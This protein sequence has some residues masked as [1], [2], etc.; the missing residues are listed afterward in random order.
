MATAT[1]TY[2]MSPLR[3][4]LGE[5]VAI[6]VKETKYEFLKLIRTK[7]FSLSVIGFPV[8]FYIFFGLANR[9]SMGK[10]V[11]AAKYMLAGYCC[12][13]MIGAALFGIGVGLASERAQGWLELKR[14]SP[15]PSL[16]YLVAKCIT[17]QAFGVIIVGALAALA[18][19]FGGVTLTATEFAEMLGMAVVGTV[20]FAA[21]GLLIALVVPANA[22]SG[23][24]N[25]IYLPMSFMSGLWVPIQFLPN[26]FKPIA[27]YL[28]AYH[29]SQL[30]E[31]VFGYQQQNASTTTAH[32]E[33]L[34]GFMLLMLGLSWAVFHRAEQD[35]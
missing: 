18:V 26:F 33:G 27:P 15:M 32:W 6:Y 29:L 4:T 11:V 8:M 14:S 22:A 28:P 20:P 9:G 16:A 34:A 23:V 35:A 7:V 5:T 30:M 21:M 17:A 19:A 3:R 1:V 24:V 31:T 2:S 13:G 25:L 12:F 10:S